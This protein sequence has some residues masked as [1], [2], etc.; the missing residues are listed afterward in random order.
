MAKPTRSSSKVVTKKHLARQEREQ[1]QTRFIL[2]SAAVVVFLVVV[3]IGYGVLD[4]NVFQPNRPIAKVG[5]SSIPLKELKANVMYRNISYIQNYEQIAQ[6]FGEDASFRQQYQSAIDNLASSV[7]ES[8]V[9]DRLIRQEAARRHIT[10]SKAEV[11]KAMQDQ[12]GYYPDGTPTAAPTSS[13]VPTRATSTLSPLQMTLVPFTPTS[14]ATPTPL[15]TP[16]VVTYTATL[17]PTSVLLTVTQT[18]TPTATAVATATEGP[19]STPNPTSTPFTQDAYNKLYQSYTQFYGTYK[20]SESEL[21]R[22]VESQLY[23]DKVQA[24][25]LADPQAIPNEQEYIWARH[26]LVTSEISATEI[27]SK[28]NQGDDFATL[29]TLYSIDTGS[30]TKGGD[31][32]WFPRGQMVPEFDTAA[33]GLANIGDYT[34]QPVQSTFGYHIIQ[35]LGREN[36]PFTSDTEKFQYWIYMQKQ[37]VKISTSTDLQLLNMLPT[38]FP[39]PTAQIQPTQSLP[40]ILVT[41]QETATP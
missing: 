11:D 3:L 41:P 19:T 28:L 5:G 25:L 20:I 2:I 26:I 22:I 15:V 4:Q 40:Q 1:L 7:Q 9:E 13:P 12:L 30:Q 39:L 27:I 18:V 37:A 38:P 33:F 35:L 29:A 34:Q 14:T 32:G 8:L 31:L 17:A 16:T 23:R 36:R 21:R 6:Y 10:V 24:A